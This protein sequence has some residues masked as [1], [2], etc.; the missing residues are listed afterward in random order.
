MSA[1]VPAPTANAGENIIPAKNRRIH[2]VQIFCENPAP[3]VKSAPRGGEIRYTIRRPYVSES[4]AA[5]IGPNPSAMTKKVSGRRAT[6]LEIPKSSLS[7][8]KAGATMEEPI[9]LYRISIKIVC[10]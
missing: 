2:N 7:P 8:S 9:V 10:I 3:M 6:V 1:T 4:G 5:R